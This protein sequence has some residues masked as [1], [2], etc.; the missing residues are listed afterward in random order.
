MTPHPTTHRGNRP[1]SIE[2]L[3]SATAVPGSGPP[4]AAGS[5]AVRTILRTGGPRP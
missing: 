3:R 2:D 4:R 5:L 1:S